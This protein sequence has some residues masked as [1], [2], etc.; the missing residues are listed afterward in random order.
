[1]TF[2]MLLNSVDTCAKSKYCT[3]VLKLQL[4]Y[5]E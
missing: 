2:E 5:A 1:M 3:F 4:T